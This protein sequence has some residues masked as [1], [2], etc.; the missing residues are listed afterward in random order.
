MGEHLELW[1]GVECTKNRVGDQFF[2]QLDRNGHE[3]RASDLERF[4]ALGVR[5]LRHPVLWGRVCPERPDVPDWRRADACLG[6]IRELGITPIVG[7][8]HHGSGPRYTDLLDPQFPEKLA[9]YAR[10][11]AERYPWVR[12]Y[13]PVNEP[14]T[15]ARFSALYGHWYPHAR[16]EAKFARALLNQVRG[17]ALA[18]EEIRRVNPEARLVQT[19]DLGMTHATPQ[20]RADAEFQNERRWLTWDLL[21]GR[22]AP[23][24]VMR[25][26]FRAHGVPEGELQWFVEHPCPPDIIGINHYVTSERFL[27]HRMDRY[28]RCTYGGVDR[29]RY[30][31]IEAVR[32]R[33]AGLVGPEAL[34]METWQRY[35]L[36]IAVTECHLGCTREEQLRWLLAMWNAAQSA[37]DRGADIRAVTVWSLL[38]AYDWCSLVCKDCGSYEPGPFDLRAPQPRPTALATMMRQL[39]SGETPEHPVLQAPG[40]WQ[41]PIRLLYPEH[42]AAAQAPRAADEPTP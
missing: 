4:A 14:L 10:T 11:V 26:H 21:C 3:E 22:F 2:D 5:A 20:L 40:W 7:L 39:G 8:V 29:D 12:M 42:D 31:D 33:T 37:K 27:D 38:G 34:L 35:A 24:H 9:A 13:T 16:D 32:I 36:P 1:G 18:M 30:A 41:R 15:T 6:R 19:D 28:P 17:V 23:D 25:R